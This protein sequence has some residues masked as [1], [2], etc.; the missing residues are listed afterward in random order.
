MLTVSSQKGRRI[1]D[2]PWLFYLRLHYISGK[3]VYIHRKNC[4]W[5]S[6]FMWQITLKTLLTISTQFVG[7]VG[8]G[9]R[10]EWLDFVGD[11]DSSVDS[12]SC[13]TL[14]LTMM[15]TVYNDTFQCI[16]TSY[17]RILMKDYGGVEA[18][19]LTSQILL[20]IRFRRRIHSSWIRIQIIAQLYCCFESV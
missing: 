7:R 3:E 5:V 4:C 19:G 15:D 10:R 6:P 17:E 16:L 9:L 1:A 20:A 8:H 13:R 11:S 12:G 14:Y 18:Q 2:P